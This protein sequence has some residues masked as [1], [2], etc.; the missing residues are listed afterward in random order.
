M[1]MKEIEWSLKNNP[2]RIE[3][4]SSSTTITDKLRRRANR[5]AKIQ[6]LQEQGKYKNAD[7]RRREAS[8]KKYEKR[9]MK[10]R[11]TV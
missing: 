7:T 8:H 10:I 9:A 5:V 1:I 11:S 4:I 6:S 2:D 3:F